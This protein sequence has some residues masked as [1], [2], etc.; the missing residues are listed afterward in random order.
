MTY[1]AGL[2]KDKRNLAALM[3]KR[4]PNYGVDAR[5]ALAES[6]LDA[7]AVSP[8]NAQGVMQLISDTQDRFGVQKPFDAEQNIKGGL[9]CLKWLQT[10]F[11]GTLTLV[12]AANKAGRAMWIVTAKFLRSEKRKT[13]CDECSASPGWIE[14]Q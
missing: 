13:T 3:R 2:T 9:A 12:A 4:A 1:I 6:N 7:S 5:M 8:K 14:G 11:S 10:R